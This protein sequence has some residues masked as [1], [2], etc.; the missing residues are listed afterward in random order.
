MHQDD[1]SKSK[2]GTHSAKKPCRQVLT[3]KE[4]FQTCET[5]MKKERGSTEHL[6]V[7]AL[8][9]DY[10][11]RSSQM[12]LQDKNFFAESPIQELIADEI[13]GALSDEDWNEAKVLQYVQKM[14]EPG[15]WADHIVIVKLQV[16]S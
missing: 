11:Q 9:C 1:E 12:I 6:H 8:V 16:R 3:E 4:L 7:R 13:V 2:N 5:M 10:M 15:V 14:R